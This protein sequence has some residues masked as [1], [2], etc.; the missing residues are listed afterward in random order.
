MA[1]S[2]LLRLVIQ[3]DTQGAVRGMEQ[4]GT[5]AERNLKKA[6]DRTAKLSANLQ[7]FGARAVVTGS[8]AAAGLYKAGEAAADL[9]QAV[10]GTE[11][12]FKG[13]SGVIDEF[14]KDAATNFGL[15]ERAA[16]E[17]TTSIGGQ[18][19][20][21]GFSVDEAAD[22]AIELTGVAADLA[23][24][25]GGTTAE[26][27]AALGAAFRGEAD[28]AERFNLF[29]NQNRVNAEAV[30]LGLAETTSQVDANAKAQATLSLITRQSADAQGQFAREAGAAAGS[31]AIAAA[32]FENAKASLGQSIAPIMADVAQKVSGLASGFQKANE[33]SGGLLSSLAAYGTIALTAGGGI[34]YVV[35]KAI[36]LK[37]SLKDAGNAGK[38]L[39]SA[40]VL[41][42]AIAL[43]KALEDAFS[44]ATVTVEEFQKL[45]DAEML[46]TFDKATKGWEKLGGDGMAP[47]EALAEQSIGTAQRLRDEIAASGEDTA[48]YDR[49]LEEAARGLAQQAEDSERAA[50]ATEELTGAVDGTTEAL[51]EQVMTL[52]ELTEATT[53]QFDASLGYRQAV[54]DAQDAVDG[55]TKTN[56]D[57]E[58]SERDKA[59]A[60]I[61]AE[62]AMIDQAEAAGKAAEQQAIL[63]GQTDTAAAY[64][65]AYRSELVK[66]RDS[67][68]PG[69]PLRAALDGY[70]AKLDSIKPN[71]DT[72][73]TATLRD[74]VTGRLNALAQRAALALN[75]G[76]PRAAGGPVNPS[77]YYVVGEKGPE[78][79]VPDSAGTIVPN[80][81]GG[82]A[83]SV[84]SGGGQTIVVQIGDEVLARVV[85]NA[86]ATGKR[87]GVAA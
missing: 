27:V 33:A 76:G 36:E 53:A 54:L 8:I 47:F 64:N 24:T 51:Q 35:G 11:A 2:E 19:K 28:P 43:S 44:T 56:E 73:V 1:A 14:A 72:T 23:A 25:Y 66:L 15:S 78:L 71:Y 5:A 32:E 69:S 77:S 41:G 86:N 67:L 82:S 52:E 79:F 30:A 37:S 38:L 59:A 10:G 61:D 87:R 3:A 17:A 83:A 48:A 45:G 7:K 31:M 68:A 13:T 4:F 26:A 81:G 20:G 55:L 46:S 50:T 6:D 34:A 63:N 70:I 74:E 62:S 9:E 39:G 18:L 84:A 29:L 75:F 42:G 85:A 58:A 21:L 60:L 49:I 22:K 40:A 16:R 65:E 57:A 80:G 12:V